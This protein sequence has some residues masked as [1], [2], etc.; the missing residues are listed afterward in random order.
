MAVSD[1]PWGQF[2]EADYTPAEFCRAALI[3]TNPSGPVTKAK[4]K[5]PVMEPNGDINRNGVHAAA[6]V[7]AGARGGV[8]AKASDKRFAAKRLIGW[9]RVL[10]EDPPDSLVSLAR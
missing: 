2:S 7:L 3:D 1:K 5:L 10:K 9:Y 8:D 6:A 4:C